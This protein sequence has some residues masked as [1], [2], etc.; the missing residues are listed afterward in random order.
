MNYKKLFGTILL[1]AA[2]ALSGFAAVT[3]VDEAP[4]WQ[5]DLSG[6]ESRPDWQE[7]DASS[8]SD[9]AVMI[10]TIEEALQPYAT[11]DDLLAIFVGDEL[12][13]LA[14][15]L[16]TGDGTV[17]A[18]RFLLRGYSNEGT[19]DEVTVT[20]KYYNAQLRQLFSLSE[21]MT[22]DEDS[23]YGIYDD[24]IP[25]FT[26]GSAKYPVVDTIPVADILIGITPGEGDVLAA[27][28]D[29]ECRGL[30]TAGDGENLNVLLL[31]ESEDVV[32]MYY[33]A[34]GNR[35]ITS[36]DGKIC[37]PGDVNC[38]GAVNV[39]DVS[40]IITAMASGSA[41]DTPA[42]A[43]V[44]GDGKVDVADIGSVIRIMSAN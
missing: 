32:L 33:D 30:W 22:L 44:N 43:D 11:A 26:L 16:T 10:V 25:P 42:T 17:D 29:G 14:S 5:I 37:Q 8:F 15:P 40:A 9:F 19:G 18:T 23:D 35:I 41:D 38:D 24:F 4:G 7:P 21:D 6:N 39:A 1:S 36:A 13:G 28:V 31:D 34:D 2:T 12:R 3:P 27:F 20:L